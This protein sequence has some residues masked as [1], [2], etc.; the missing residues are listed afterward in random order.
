MIMKTFPNLLLRS[1]ILLSF[2]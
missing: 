2:T 1:I